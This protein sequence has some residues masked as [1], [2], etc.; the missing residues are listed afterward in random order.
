MRVI[1]ATSRAGYTAAGSLPRRFHLP[2]R[3]EWP[4]VGIYWGQS[5]L[6]FRLKVAPSVRRLRSSPRVAGVL[7]RGPE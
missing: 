3:L 6:R 2:R 4:R 7:D 5:W 1:E